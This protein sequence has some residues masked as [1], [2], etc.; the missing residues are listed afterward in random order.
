MASAYRLSVVATV[1]NLGLAACAS[2]NLTDLT[3]DVI[4]DVLQDL[5]DK[6]NSPAEPRGQPVRND[7]APAKPTGGGGRASPPSQQK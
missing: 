1:V 3:S 2:N 5:S 6:S 7:P 4:T